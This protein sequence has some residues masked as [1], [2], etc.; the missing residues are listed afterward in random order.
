MSD[1]LTEQHRRVQLAIGARTVTRLLTLWRLLD[2]ADLRRTTPGWLDAALLVIAELHALSAS[3][4]RSYY[5]DLRTRRLGASFTGTLAVPAFSADAA[6]TSLTVTGPVALER[7]RRRGI[8][9]ETASTAAALSSARAGSRVAMLGGRETVM[10]ATR[11]D[12]RARGWVRVTGGDPCA[13]CVMLADRGAVYSET[14]ADF[15]AHANCACQP[16]PAFT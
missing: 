12:T 14:T 4:A 7:A 11:A 1:P 13:F 5:R 10:A 16:E 15:P 8:A 3:A 9:L 6:R 2:P